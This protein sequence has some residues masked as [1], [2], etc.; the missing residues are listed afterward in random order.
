MENNNKTSVEKLNELLVENYK[1]TRQLHQAII[2]M[3]GRLSDENNKIVEKID[4]LEQQI[5]KLNN[6]KELVNTDGKLRKSFR[7]Y[8]DEEI[9][10][11]RYST[12][13]RK[14]AS[15]LGCST[16]TI[17]RICRRYKLND[18]IID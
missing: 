17:Q 11:L 4:S 1:A 2:S 6:N 18:E 16:S 8:T 13:L 9:Y 14:C 7:D 12:S 10:N 15:Q 3:Q 5:N